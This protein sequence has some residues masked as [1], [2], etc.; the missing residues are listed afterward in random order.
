MDIGGDGGEVGDRARRE[1]AGDPF[2]V[3]L[4]RSEHAPPNQPTVAGVGRRLEAEF[5]EAREAFV[6]SAAMIETSAFED[7]DGLNG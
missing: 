3:S 5:F 2:R 4:R 1:A 7:A 6:G